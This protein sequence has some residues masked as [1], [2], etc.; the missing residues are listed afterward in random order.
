MNYLLLKTMETFAVQGGWFLSLIKPGTQIES[1]HYITCSE[2]TK[3]NVHRTSL[4]AISSRPYFLNKKWIVRGQVLR[5]PKS[6]YVDETIQNL[7]RFLCLA[8][9]ISSFFFPVCI[10]SYIILFFVAEQQIIATIIAVIMESTSQ[11]ELSLCSGF[12]THNTT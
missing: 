9:F 10:C 5:K 7:Y 4:G 12:L 2:T 6:Q 3:E 11:H 8:C 1:K